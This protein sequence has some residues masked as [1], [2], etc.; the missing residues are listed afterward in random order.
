MAPSRINAASNSLLAT[1]DEGAPLD[2]LP[3]VT[4]DLAARWARAR[5]S[6]LL[7]TGIAEM[8][9]PEPELV[10][11]AL[12]LDRALCLKLA[13]DN[14]RQLGLGFRRFYEVDVPLQNLASLLPELGAPC[15]R[16]T[17]QRVD[18]PPHFRLEREPCAWR[19][20]CSTIGAFFREATDGLVLG[21]SSSAH[22]AR[23]QSRAAGDSLCLDVLFVRDAKMLRYGPLPETMQ[24][25][26]AEAKKLASTFD[27]ETEVEFLGVSEGTLFYALKTNPAHPGVR[28]KPSLERALLRR[29]PHLS[30]VD[31]T[32]TEVSLDSARK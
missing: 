24:P 31:V 9:Q 23:H 3:T 32:P 14:S 7:A 29:F 11:A 18:A 4:K 20:N 6:A 10:E 30:F 5:R 15:L 19:E 12:S 28:I 26:L 21:L 16:G 27:S 1:P 8:N 13:F 2:S 25:G 17:W 22:F